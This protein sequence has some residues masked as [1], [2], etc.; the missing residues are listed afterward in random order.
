MN[1]AR[2][3]AYL[4]L[5]KSTRDDAFANLQVNSVLQ[6]KELSPE[7]KALFHHLYFG[8]VEKKITLDYLLSQI[9]SVPLNRLDT[10]VLCNLELASFQILYSKRI[11]DHAAIFEAGEIAKRCFPSSL[12]LTNAVLRRLSREK[13][14]VWEHLEI[15]GKKGLALRYG[16]P[17]YLVSIWQEAYGKE[18]CEKI[19]FAQNQRAPMTLRVNTLKTTLDEYASLLEKKGIPF[20]Q[21]PLCKNGLTLEKSENPTLLP[22]YEEGLFFIQDAAASHATD[23]LGAKKGDRVLDLCAAPGGK[24]YGAAM[25]MEGEGEILSLELHENRLPLIMEGAKR[26]G[27][28]CMTAEQNDSSVAKEKHAE[29]FDRVICDVPCSGWG[30]ISKKPDIRHKTKEEGDSLPA[31]QRTILE[32]AAKAVK[33]GGFIL[34]STCTLNP[35]ENEE[36]TNAFLASHSEFSRVGEYETIFPVGSENDGFFCD[37][38][39]KE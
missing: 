19:L 28:D 17:R 26:L 33:K 39:K 36:V 16:Y 8:V 37:L 27:I 13:D 12:S 22:G 29:A 32:V 11:P 4:S 24:S 5:V 2:Y 9:C 21:N 35:K 20:H 23:R 1:P 15:P 25:D 6:Q 3:A 34:Y 31:L 18:Q 10:E 14:S 30:T 38:L 7:D